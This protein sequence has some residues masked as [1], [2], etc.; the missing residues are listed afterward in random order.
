MYRHDHASTW[1]Y[2]CLNEV[3]IHVV[4]LA[5]I[6]QHR[7]CPAVNNNRHGRDESMCYGDNLV[8]RFNPRCQQGDMHGI[9]SAVDAHS[10]AQTQIIGYIPLKLADIV[11]EYQ[12]TPG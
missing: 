6:H 11:A 3:N 12:V 9:R 10:M 4:I 8:T 5:D 2:R 1:C 7:C